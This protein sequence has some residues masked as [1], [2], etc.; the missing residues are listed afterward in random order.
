MSLAHT[1][2]WSRK[3]QLSLRDR[4]IKK[5]GI[6]VE[7]CGCHGCRKQSAPLVV[8]YERTWYSQECRPE[9]RRRRFGR[10]CCLLGSGEQRNRKGRAQAAERATRGSAGIPNGRGPSGPE[11]R[12]ESDAFLPF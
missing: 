2:Y 10:A 3:E 5:E 1:E 11:R 12:P 6:S 7:S 4:K 9:E 8:A